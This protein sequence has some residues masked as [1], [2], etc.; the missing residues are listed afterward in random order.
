VDITRRLNQYYN[1]N[2]LT[3]S[4]PLRGSPSGMYINRAL[5]KGGYSS[6][7]LCILEYCEPS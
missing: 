2:Y 1:I 3:K 5:L 7:S 6:F 4:D